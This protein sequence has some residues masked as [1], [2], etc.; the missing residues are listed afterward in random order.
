MRNSR[1]SKVELLRCLMMVGVCMWHV[2]VHGLNYTSL[3]TNE[4]PISL[5]LVD[6]LLLVVFVPAVNTFMLISGYYGI[7]LSRKK[8]FALVSPVYF[9][10]FVGI[11]VQ[12]MFSRPVWGVF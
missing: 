10:F 9:Y 2:L 1:N 6:V 8:L 12:Y 4:G 7:S 11:M 3:G 5:P